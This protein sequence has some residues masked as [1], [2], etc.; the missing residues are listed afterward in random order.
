MTRQTDNERLLADVMADESDTAF[1]EALLGK[2]LRLARRRRRFRQTR[3]AG[4]AFAVLIGLAVLVWQCFPPPVVSPASN[5]GKY[6]IIRT[7]PLPATSIVTTRSLPADRLIASVTTANTIETLPDARLFREIS[8]DELL[9]MIAP[10]V[11]ALVR[12]GPHKA[13]LVVLEPAAQETSPPN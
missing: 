8:D 11:A 1:H 5:R 12:L 9:A 10:K 2:T 6:A 7:V 3:R 4:M 13:E